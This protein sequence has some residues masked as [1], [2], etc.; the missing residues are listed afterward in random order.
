M[1]ENEWEDAQIEQYE[2]DQA[3]EIKHRREHFKKELSKVTD[4]LL[5]LKY[6]VEARNSKFI[7]EIVPEQSFP[8]FDIA[9]SIKANGWTPSAKQREALENV[10]AYYYATH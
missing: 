1:F 7:N 9:L 4:E 3:D 6:Q 8:A 5:L 10:L 2:Q